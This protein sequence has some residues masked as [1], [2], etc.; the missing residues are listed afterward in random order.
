MPT[1]WPS[2]PARSFS[3]RGS[4]RGS[5]PDIALYPAVLRPLVEA[6][7]AAAVN[8][9]SV[10]ALGYPALL[11]THDYEERAVLARLEKQS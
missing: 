6:R 11:I 3:A 7:G 2:T 5:V 9:A 4:A 10:A 1:A 8:E